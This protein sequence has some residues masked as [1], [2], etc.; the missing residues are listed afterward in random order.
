MWRVTNPPTSQKWKKN[1]WYWPHFRWKMEKKENTKK[2]CQ[3]VSFIFN[4][5][6]TYK[7]KKEKGILEKSTAQPNPKFS[8]SMHVLDCPM[9][10]ISDT[11]QLHNHKGLFLSGCCDFKV[12]ANKILS[13]LHLFH[14]VHNHLKTL[15][16]KHW[17][18]ETMC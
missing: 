5:M 3:G 6:Y 13:I 14:L 1:P 8:L 17:P 2:C 16:V 9:C 11:K 15:Q 10:C 18:N 7:I 12:Y 4:N